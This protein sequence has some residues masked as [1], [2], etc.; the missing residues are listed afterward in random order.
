MHTTLAAKKDLQRV[1]TPELCPLPRPSRGLPVP[2]GAS[3]GPRCPLDPSG[4]PAAALGPRSA[5]PG[6]RRQPLT[7]HPRGANP[8]GKARTPSRALGPHSVATEA[9]KAKR[10]HAK[11]L[12]LIPPGTPAPG[13][14]SLPPSGPPVPLAASLLAHDQ[15]EDGSIPP[16]HHPTLK[17]NQYPLSAPPSL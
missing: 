4:R 11:I 6:A 7:H 2:R 9:P 12:C 13:I 8:S 16:P 15:Y 5:E 1:T 14:S 17:M 3:G 10:S